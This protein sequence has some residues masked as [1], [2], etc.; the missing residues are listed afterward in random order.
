MKR[1]IDLLALTVTLLGAWHL[2][3]PAPLAA[4][5]APTNPPGMYCW[6]MTPLT[7]IFQSPPPILRSR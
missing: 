5:L 2:G 7:Q 1:R 4:T 6:S 3:R